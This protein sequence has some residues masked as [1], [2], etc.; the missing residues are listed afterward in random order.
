MVYAPWVR[1]L[2]DR[3]CPDG[4][5]SRVNEC[6]LSVEGKHHDARDALGRGA[7]VVAA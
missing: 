6:H 4:P 2:S 7:L 5:R 1:V 3:V